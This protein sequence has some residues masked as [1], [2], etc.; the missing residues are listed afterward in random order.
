MPRQWGGELL[1][2]FIIS[3]VLRNIPACLLSNY[4]LFVSLAGGYVTKERNVD[5]G[6]ALA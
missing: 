1:P 3:A 6:I 5:L 2:K 4:D